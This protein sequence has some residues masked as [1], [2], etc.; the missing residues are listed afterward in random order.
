LPR[1]AILAHVDPDRAYLELAIELD[2]DPIS[3]YLATKPG[4]PRNF[5]GWIELVAA[6]EDAR[7]GR[8]VAPR[9]AVTWLPVPGSANS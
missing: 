8:Q 1:R 5:S 6:I 3:G 4:E 2:S 7:G 9:A